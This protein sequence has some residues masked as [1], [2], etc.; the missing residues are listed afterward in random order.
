[1][2]S[3]ST[4]EYAW[5][6]PA[7]SQPILI[8]EDDPGMRAALAALLNS[9][10]RT[11]VTARNA[12]E[13]LAHLR[14]GGR[15]CLIILDLGLPG[16]SGVAFRAAL[17]ADLALADIPVIIYSAQDGSAVPHVFGH[18]S[19]SADPDVLLSLVAK[20]CDGQG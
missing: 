5:S 6:V 3:P 10:Q 14:S 4:S 18:V 1:M 15:T 20:V 19:K 9:S 13:A 7:L 11:T 2:A 16:I 12:E 8:V 17:L